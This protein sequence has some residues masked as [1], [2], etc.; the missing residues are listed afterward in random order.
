MDF[1]M[2]KNIFRKAF[3][4]GLSV[5]LSNEIA[6]ADVSSFVTQKGS[7]LLLDGKEF[8]FS[9]TNNY[10]MHYA[11]HDMIEAVLDDALKMGVKVLRVWG[12]MDGVH[13]GHTAQVEAFS[14]EVPSGVESS[15]DKL[16]FTVSEAKKRGIRIVI[17]LTNNWDDF[18]GIPEYVK[19]FNADSHDDF[20]TNEKIKE[21]YKAYA[22]YLINHENKYTHIKNCDEP[23]IMTWELC[24]EPR[25]QSDK[26]GNKLYEWAKSMSEYIHELAPN[27]LVAIGSEG[28]FNRKNE[29]DWTYNG[30]DG[31]DFDRLI[32]LDSVNYGTFH[33]YPK[34][35][36]KLNP[37]E[38]GTQW[39]LDH[40]KSAKAAKKPVVLEEY[41]IGKDESVNR[42]YIYRKWTK[43]AYESGI[44][45]TMFWILTSK[46]D[47]SEDGLYPDYDGFR[48]LC[49]QSET[50]EILKSH[51]QMMDTG[52][53]IEKNEFY[54]VSPKSHSEVDSDN[55][56]IK[57]AAYTKK[58]V[59]PGKLSVIC[60]EGKLNTEVTEPDKDGFYELKVNKSELGIGKHKFKV[61]VEFSDR[62][63]LERELVLDFVPNIDHY[64]TVQT[65]DFSNNESEFIDGGCY[66]AEFESNPVETD[67]ALGML[68]I[69]ARMSGK[70]DWE[71]VRVH[72]ADFPK[73]ENSSTVKFNLFYPYTDD[74]NAGARPYFVAGDGWLKL[75]V[76]ANSV[77]LQDLKVVE[78]RG[79]K[80]FKHDVKIELG[81]LKGKKG[82]FYICPVGNKYKLNKPM[83]LD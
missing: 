83:Y 59:T 62:S 35:W 29:A 58:G 8:R 10:Y 23:A 22:K 11:S 82:D 30:N 41:G 45:G 2:G 79:E 3:I 52:R 53:T 25:A 71:E 65:F 78:I 72:F 6:F 18:G 80:Y 5:M 20:Y 60:D 7:S 17:A 21:C 70:N 63:K 54:I 24:N 36:S 19:W 67:S 39:I 34:T 73:L 48:I 49:D 32:K 42:S 4:L 76:D 37:E 9:G 74:I 40:A 38:W 28:F 68:K 50:S 27:Q 77:K 16:D 47:K 69:N 44:S 13:H 46:D 61:S 64:E 55:T 81:S 33:L 12:F 51:S 75:G 43:T 15:I 66:Q 1:T 14:Y 31:V 26:S 57:V 56:V